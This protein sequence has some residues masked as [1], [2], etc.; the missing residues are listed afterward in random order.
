MILNRLDEVTP[1]ELA[2]GLYILLLSGTSDRATYEKMRDRRL[3]PA[4]VAIVAAAGRPDFAPPS[5]SDEEAERVTTAATGLLGD[6]ARP[7]D[8]T[9]I[10]TLMQLLNASND[11][12]SLAAAVALGQIGAVEAGEPVVALT[13]RLL[14]KGELGAVARLARALARIGDEDALIF[15]Q[16]LATQGQASG[17]KQMGYL[18]TTAEESARELGNRLM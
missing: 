9:V 7:G 1:E 15:L 8:Q 2:Q 6:I 14:D 11:R 10:A 12:V 3:L 17:D 4:L 18:A 16:T 5:M 13:R